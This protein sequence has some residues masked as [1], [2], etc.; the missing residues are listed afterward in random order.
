VKT[1]N[2]DIQQVDLIRTK[3]SRAPAVVHYTG[4]D[5]P[6]QGTSHGLQ[7]GGLVTFTSKF[8]LLTMVRIYESRP[9]SFL[10]VMDS[11]YSSLRV[12]LLSKSLLWYL[13]HLIETKN[14]NKPPFWRPWSIN[15][16]SCVASVIGCSWLSNVL[17]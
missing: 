3:A 5:R 4:V 2:T 14:V 6:G 12:I 9:A 7:N 17:G 15:I 1:R 13:R 8:A 10:T 11:Q 16:L